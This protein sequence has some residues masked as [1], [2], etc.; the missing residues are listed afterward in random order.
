MRRI[1]LTGWIL[2]EIKKEPVTEAELEEMYSHTK[3]YEALFSQRSTQIKE[4]GVEVSSLSE[5]DFRHLI[6]EHYSF[7]KRPVFLTHEILF[8]GNQKSTVEQLEK[9]FAG[10]R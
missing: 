3:C 7:L 4:R 9:Y 1:D 5:E 6:L 8:A 2:R 10:H